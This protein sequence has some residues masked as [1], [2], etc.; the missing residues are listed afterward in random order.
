[1]LCWEHLG[2]IEHVSMQG[3]RTKRERIGFLYFTM[4]GKFVERVLDGSS[5]VNAYCI[6]LK[7]FDSTM[8][9]RTGSQYLSNVIY[10]EVFGLAVS[11]AQGYRRPLCHSLHD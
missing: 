6:T 9:D 11:F 2:F 3:K 1:M 5:G 8:H 10:Q 4:S 7:K